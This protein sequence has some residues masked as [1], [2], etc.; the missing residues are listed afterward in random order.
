[1]RTEEATPPHAPAIIV[2]LWL[3]WFVPP[4]APYLQQSQKNNKQS[5]QINIKK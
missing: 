5:L 4:A 3:R 1:M 2:W